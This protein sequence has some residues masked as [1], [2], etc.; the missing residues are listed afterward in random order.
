MRSWTWLMLAFLCLPL[1][2][3]QAQDTAEEDAAESEEEAEEET[4]AVEPA[5]ASEP[6]PATEPAP[7][8]K[9]EPAP[10]VAEEPAPEEGSAK[11]LP[12]KGDATEEEAVVAAEPPAE[13]TDG[14][15]VSGGKPI[16]FFE[17]YG[18]FSV[19]HFFTYNLFMNGNNPYLPTTPLANDTERGEKILSWAMLKLHLEPIINVSETMEIHSKLTLMGS[20]LIGTDDAV[21]QTQENGLLPGTQWAVDPSIRVEGLWGTLDTPIGELRVGRMPFHWGL[22]ILYNDAN[23]VDTDTPGDYLDRV[24][25]LVPIM[26]FKII[27][28]FD[29]ISEGTMVRYND[30]FIDASSRDDGWQLG[31]M[32]TMQEDDPA[33]LEEKLLKENTVYEFGALLMYA[34]K[35]DASTLIDAG[36]DTERYVLTEQDSR[37]FTFDIWGN[38]YYKNFSLKAELAFLDGK[39]GR[40]QTADLAGRIDAQMFGAALEAQW[41]YIPRKLHFTL[42]G[43]VATGDK[44]SGVQGDSVNLPGNAIDAALGLDTKVENFRFHRD[45]NFNSFIWREALGRFTS[46]YYASFDTQY[47]FLDEISMRGGL[48]Y[49]GAWFA[50]QTPGGKG[51]ALA[52]EPYLGATYEGESGLRAGLTFQIA[53]PF[54]GLNTVARNTT[55]LFDIHTYMG[56]VF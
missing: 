32:F 30:H 21:A 39:L 31:L 36:T 13:Q 1:F 17:L 6:A 2:S 46:G 7:V 22:G 10:A 41:K 26:G 56:F 24:L 27:P 51:T 52:L 18:F 54:D 55:V 42:L 40:Y 19:N 20:R 37:I 33:V 29:Y 48:T 35:S 45:Y 25:F 47:Y 8:P 23:R 15:K 11:V 44:A 14:L 3:L 34:W 12:P 50:K 5:P 53:V 9:S 43:G 28:F 4:A 16:K 38:L 49:S